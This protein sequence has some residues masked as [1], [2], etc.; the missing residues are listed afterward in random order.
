MESKHDQ[1]SGP[2]EARNDLSAIASLPDAGPGE[3]RM[4]QLCEVFLEFFHSPVDS[5]ALDSRIDTRQPPQ[6]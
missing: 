6:S 1:R 5:G 3:R 4:F 2:Y